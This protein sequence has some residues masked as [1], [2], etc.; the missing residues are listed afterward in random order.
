MMLKYP[1][2]II[3]CPRLQSYFKVP[4]DVEGFMAQRA[5]KRS[6]RIGKSSSLVVSVVMLVEKGAVQYGLNDWYCMKTINVYLPGA[7]KGRSCSAAQLLG[8]LKE[9]IRSTPS[10]MKDLDEEQQLL[11]VMPGLLRKA[12]SFSLNTPRAPMSQYLGKLPGSVANREYHEKAE[13]LMKFSD[14]VSRH[15]FLARHN[16]LC[17]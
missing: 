8:K 5:T 16:K 10:F 9:S 12:H 13:D 14:M 7:T 1:Y 6:L 17:R 3:N 11:A 4:H 2:R 15:T